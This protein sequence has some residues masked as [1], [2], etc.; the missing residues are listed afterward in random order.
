MLRIEKV[1]PTEQVGEYLSQHLPGEVNDF[2][3]IGIAS[4][5]EIDGEVAFINVDGKRE[6]NYEFRLAIEIV[7]EGSG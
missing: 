1:V 7:H 2:T 6:I 3:G 5:P 4:V